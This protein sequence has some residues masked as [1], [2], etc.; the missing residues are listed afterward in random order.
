MNQAS[1]QSPVILFDFDGTL[2]DT[3]AMKTQIEQ[4]LTPI[5]ISFTKL[6]AIEK[7]LRGTSSHIS[8][9]IKQFC[10]Q[11]GLQDQIDKIQSIFLHQDFSSFLFEDS[12]PTLTN[13][14]TKCT[15]CLFTQGD[16]SYQQVKVYGSNIQTH[17]AHLFIFHNKI[18]HLLE[19]TTQFAERDMYFIDNHVKY[20]QKASELMPSIKTIWINREGI[21]NNSSY[22]PTFETNS[23]TELEQTIRF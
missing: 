18:D 14:S 19:I 2:F 1:T 17:F 7:S 8:E 16:E 15:Q 12:I 5:T 20:L 9:T 10:E 13:L 22:T 3:T 23:L 11:E 6:W 21:V 4:D